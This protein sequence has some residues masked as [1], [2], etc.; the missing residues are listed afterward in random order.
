MKRKVEEMLSGS[1][2]DWKVQGEE[3]VETG[4]APSLNRGAF[5]PKSRI[6]E[7]T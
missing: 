4:H 1:L 6:P 7:K 2:N 5:Q 3:G